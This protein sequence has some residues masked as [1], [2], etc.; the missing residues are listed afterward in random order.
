MK[1]LLILPICNLHRGSM[2]WCC[3]PSPASKTHLCA[4]NHQLSLL[5]PKEM[6]ERRV[7]HNRESSL[8]TKDETFRVKEGFPAAVPRKV[9]E[10]WS[11]MRRFGGG[12]YRRVVGVVRGAGRVCWWCLSSPRRV[13]RVLEGKPD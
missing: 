13:K 4:E 8:T 1:I 3:V 10:I 2:S 6:G 11:G 12:G 9:T 7:T 5:L